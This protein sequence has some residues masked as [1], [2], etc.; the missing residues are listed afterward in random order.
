[1][2][3]DFPSNV[4]SVLSTFYL[5]YPNSVD[6]ERFVK[7]EATAM[8]NMNIAISNSILVTDGYAAI[9]RTTPLQLAVEMTDS[10][11]R[12]ATWIYS[13]MHV[14]APGYSWTAEQISTWTMFY[15]LQG[16]YGAFRMYKEA[17]NVCLDPKT[18]LDAMLRRAFFMFGKAPSPMTFLI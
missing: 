1:M 15:Y 8:E 12:T 11:L 2:A 10:P 18:Y 13:I 5:V 7:N 14:A 16:P 4:V 3:T 9:Q 6:L 17:T